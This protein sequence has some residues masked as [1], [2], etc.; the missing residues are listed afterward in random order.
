ML[1]QVPIALDIVLVMDTIDCIV[2]LSDSVDLEVAVI[3]FDS[4]EDFP[5]VSAWVVGLPL[6][7]R[8][9]AFALLRDGLELFLVFF[10][11]QAD[12]TL[13]DRLPPSP[14]GALATRQRVA[15]GPKLGQRAMRGCV[16]FPGIRACRPQPGLL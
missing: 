7:L 6:M 12:P 9:F 1:V 5:P 11:W 14:R 16:R 15:N 13:F 3:A 2:E 8:V 10:S 4:F